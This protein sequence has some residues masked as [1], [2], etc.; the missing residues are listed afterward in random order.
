MAF[1]TGRPGTPWNDSLFIGSLAE[2]NLIR[3]SL[4]GDKIVGEERLLNEIGE[5]VRDVRIGPDDHVYV[6]TDEVDGKLF[7]I[8][9][10][11]AP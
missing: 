2:R 9:P 11:K 7:R 8:Q 6:L 5:R 3:L 4:D 10:P 1:Y